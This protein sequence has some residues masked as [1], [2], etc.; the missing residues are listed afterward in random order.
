MIGNFSVL[1]SLPEEQVKRL[2]KEGPVAQLS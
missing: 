1:A 2:G